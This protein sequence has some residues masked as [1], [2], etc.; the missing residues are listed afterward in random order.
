VRKALRK[1][2]AREG[3]GMGAYDYD[4][5]HYVH[6]QLDAAVYEMLEVAGFPSRGSAWGLSEA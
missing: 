2:L 4:L 6:G 3:T 5:V 1:H